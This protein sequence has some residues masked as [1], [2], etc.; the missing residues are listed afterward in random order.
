MQRGKP[1][2]ICMY[3]RGLCHKCII[4]K[5]I[6]ERNENVLISISMPGWLLGLNVRAPSLLG[7][8]HNRSGQ[9]ATEVN[10]PF[11]LQL[12]CFYKYSYLV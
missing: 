12:H 8:I 2:C 4:K 6:V 10:Q 3:Y 11:Y 9:L 5:Q 1:V 7:L